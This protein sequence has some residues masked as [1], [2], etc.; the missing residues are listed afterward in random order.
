[1]AK[2]KVPRYLYH[3]TTRDTLRH[4]FKKSESGESYVEFRFT[5]YRFLNDAEEGI[6]WIKYL[7]RQSAHFKACLSPEAITFFDDLCLKAKSLLAGDDEFFYIMSFSEL[8]DS[9]QFWRQDYAKNNG[10]CLKIDTS[11]F[12]S[13]KTKK[14]YPVPPFC[15]VKYPR[16]SNHINVVFPKLKDILEGEAAKIRNGEKKFEEY[17]L[18]NLIDLLPY[19]VKNFVWKSEQEWRLQ[20]PGAKYAFYKEIYEI[21]DKGIPRAK[22]WIDNPFK[23]IILGPTLTPSD[24]AFTKKWLVDMGFGSIDVR[25]GDGVL[26]R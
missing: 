10:V 11:R 19:D 6:F 13:L 22:I 26:N 1:M 8:E 16:L 25:C 18:E 12:K 2:G 5:D 17:A 9:M 21:D 4:I 20:M 24:A 14:G 15:Q 23:E 7:D 3:Y